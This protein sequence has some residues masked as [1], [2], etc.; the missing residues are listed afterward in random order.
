MGI[1]L[2]FPVKKKEPKELALG[3]VVSF[4]NG[5]Q[6]ITGPVVEIK[7]NKCLVAGGTINIWRVPKSECEIVANPPR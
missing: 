2:Q 6:K 7:G 4:M 5:K 1:I 3:T